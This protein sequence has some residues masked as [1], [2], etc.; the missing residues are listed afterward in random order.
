MWITRAIQRFLG[1][2]FDFSSVKHSDTVYKVIEYIRRCYFRKISLD[3][4]AQHVQFSK[5][6]LSRIFKEK[7]GENISSYIN[8]VRVDRA[9]LLLSDQDLSLVDVAALTGFEDQ[10]YFTKVFKSTTG[11]TPKNIRK[12]AVA[13]KMRQAVES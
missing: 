3:D 9:K 5:T 11:Q 7:T 12:T 4:I 8:K 6:Y 13:F 2:S 1:Y 10:S